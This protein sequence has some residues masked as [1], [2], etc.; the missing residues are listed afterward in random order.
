MTE[1]AVA[2][3]FADL[4]QQRH[5]AEVGIWIF[6]A[7]EMLF[8]GGLFLSLTVYRTLYP[9]VFSEAT[10]HLSFGLGTVNTA[11]LLTS[12]WAMALAVK[13]A[14]EGKQS[15]VAWLVLTILLGAIFLGIKWVEYHHEWQE[16]LVPAFHFNV[17]AFSSPS[18]QL[19]F[20]L[21]FLM[22][23][24]HALHLTIG[25][26]VI[27]WVARRVAKNGAVTESSRVE[28]VALYWHFVDIVWVFLY[29]MLYLL[30]RS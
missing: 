15:C 28:I 24:L 7:S 26:G 30:G 14:K 5:A 16:N 4:E 9:D 29:P 21:Y 20:L 10:R 23:G 18:A 17:T 11:V 25:L 12:S 22:T 3:Q 27:T 6:L 8:F 19:F 2:E 1:R 13:G